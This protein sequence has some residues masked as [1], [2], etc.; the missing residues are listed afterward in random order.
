MEATE[1]TP[2][3]PEPQQPDL[4]L[5]KQQEPQPDLS[6]L[7]QQDDH[8]YDIAVRAI[9]AKRE[10]TRDD[11]IQFNIIHRRSVFL[12]GFSIS[13]MLIFGLVALF[14]DKEDVLSD[15]L[16]ILCGLIGGGGLG[17]AFGSRKKS[18]DA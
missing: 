13:C 18:P 9:D 1:N 7:K 2:V 5:L 16:K 11:R 8:Q 17:Y 4:S 6:L 14:L 15:L 12:T 10:A 3:V